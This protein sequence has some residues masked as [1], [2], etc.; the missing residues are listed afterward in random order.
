MEFEAPTTTNLKKR[1]KIV[2]IGLILTSLVLTFIVYICR[3]IWMWGMLLVL[4]S[5]NDY[6]I[7]LLISS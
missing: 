6:F 4:L 2:G 5:T 7:L 3:D 1:H